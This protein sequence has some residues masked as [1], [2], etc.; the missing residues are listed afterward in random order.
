MYT[1]A[2]LGLSAARQVAL[3]VLAVVL[4]ESND[5]SDLAPRR[6]RS[7]MAPLDGLT[8]EVLTAGKAHTVSF[9][10]DGATYEIDLSP[11][12]A[13][14]LRHDL[15]PWVARARTTSRRPEPAPH[16]A[17]GRTTPRMTISG[18][19]T[20]TIRQWARVNGHA[21]SDRG[22]LPTVVHQ[23]YSSAH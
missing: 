12:K 8:G 19:D 6:R 14:A 5:Q 11:R 21:V 3:T 22:R 7:T 20:A 15:G 9:G 4:P 10:V 23:A 13:A 18:V 2:S 1:F 16:K 17:G